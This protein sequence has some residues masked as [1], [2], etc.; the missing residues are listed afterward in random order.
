MAYFN[1]SRG[2][3]AGGFRIGID[4]TEGASPSTNPEHLNAFEI[5]LKKD[6]GRTFQVNMAAFYYDY[7]NDQIPL[8]VASTAGG[9]GQA[10]SIFFNVPAAKSQGF[11]LESIWQP[12]DHLQVL[13]NYSYLDAHVTKGDGVVDPA[14]PAALAPGA[15]PDVTFAQCAAAVGTARACS[16]D[17]FTGANALVLRPDGT[18]VPVS[19]VIGAGNGGFQRPQSIVG[20]ELPNAPKNK[21]AIN[22]NYTLEFQPGSLTGSVN[23]IWRDKQFGSLFDRS[24][25]EAPAYS[26]WDARV[27]YKDKDNKYTI[28]AF[29]KNIA[30]DL[31]YEG[32]ASAGRRAGQLPGY[33]VGQTGSTAL[34]AVPVL[35][36]G[37]N[38]VGNIVSG[39]LL[40]PPRTYGIELQYRF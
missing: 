25:Y 20:S 28:I 39:Y 30:N 35:T 34:A 3:K 6:F 29:I 38:N 18:F 5:G 21:V 17:V 15:K 13:F 10:Q 14:D 2:F 31:G 36:P 37:N 11:E 24:Y 27:T 19:S 23:Y 33:V 22:V 8:T 1:F 9:L 4:T 26:Q 40:T 16:V 12:I 32:G 7:K